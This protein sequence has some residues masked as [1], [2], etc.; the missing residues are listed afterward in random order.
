MHLKSAAPAAFFCRT[1]MLPSLGFNHSAVQKKNANA[2]LRGAP[3]KLYATLT[4]IGPNS[5]QFPGI[6]FAFNAAISDIQVVSNDASFSCDAPVVTN[7]STT[8]ACASLTPL[9]YGKTAIFSATGSSNSVAFISLAASATSETGDPDP[10]NN[11]AYTNVVF[12]VDADLA[13]AISGPCNNEPYPIGAISNQI[14]NNGPLL[15]P[16]AQL[17]LELNVPASSVTLAAP[18][19]WN[20]NAFEIGPGRTFGFCAPTG[21]FANGASA[22]VLLTLSNV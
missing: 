7:G 14:S 13:A 4:N 21:T 12:R 6:G 2:H 16:E 19:G 11:S 18:A 1:E 22:D 10:S 5:A 8:V 17:T 3:F 15:Q 20:C 9:S